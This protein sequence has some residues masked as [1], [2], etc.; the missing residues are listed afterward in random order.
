MTLQTANKQT[1]A[2]WFKELITKREKLFDNHLKGHWRKYAYVRFA[3]VLLGFL[4]TVALGIRLQFEEHLIRDWLS[5]FAF[6]C[7]ALVT[8][9]MAYETVWDHR[10]EWV[11][12]RTVLE[13][14]WAIRDE[15]E[16]KCS[17]ET[18]ISE[19]EVEGLHYKLQATFSQLKQEWRGR[20]TSDGRIRAEKDALDGAL[21][22]RAS[23][24]PGLFHVTGYGQPRGDQ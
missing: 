22:R 10:W 4:S 5:N 9:L 1:S 19:K 15:F 6:F 12:H 8:V 16:F 18:S 24:P 13:G 14:I 21:H 17:R 20:K 2:E 23:D 7:T 3:I 11:A